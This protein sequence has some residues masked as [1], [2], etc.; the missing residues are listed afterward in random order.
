MLDTNPE[1][2]EKPSSMSEPV[3]R[4]WPTQVVDS[5]TLAIQIDSI[6][7]L[8]YPM[9]FNK[10]I[11]P[12]DKIVV[13]NSGTSDLRGHITV[14]IR[15][16]D[17]DLSTQSTKYVPIDKGKNEFLFED[18]NVELRPAAMLTES[19]ED[20]EIAVAIVVDDQLVV[21][22]KRTIDV[23][24]SR[25]WLYKP[26][27]AEATGL[28]LTTFVTPH[29][30]VLDTVLVKAQPH[31][32][33]L[34]KTAK[35]D[36]Y[37]RDEP[38]VIDAQV[39]AIVSALQEMDITYMN[40][41]TSWDQ[42]GQKLR[43]ATQMVGEVD[44]RA[45]T[46]LDSTILLASILE[47]IDIAPILFVVNGHAFLGY[48]RYDEGAFPNGPVEQNLDT[49]FAYIQ[50]DQ[51]RL[52]ETTLI[53]TSQLEESATSWALVQ[54]APVN[55]RFLNR[56]ESF[57][58]GIDVRYAR[59]ATK[60]R[61]IPVA[62]N[63]SDGKAV[64][65]EYL[66]PES[67]TSIFNIQR[68]PGKG[69]V[70]DRSNEPY[71]VTQWKNKLLDLS[72][73]NRLLNLTP[74]ARI[75]LAMPESGIAI[76]EDV[77]NS[78]KQIKLLPFDVSKAAEGVRNVN[79]FS[80]LAEEPIT[81]LFAKNG[82]L[83]TDLTNETY[84]AKLRNIASK[85]RVIEEETGSNNLFL[86]FGALKWTIND[87]QVSSP[88]VL[89]PIRL[90]STG[91]QTAFTFTLDDA[92]E[93]TPNFCLLEKF[94]QETD[95]KQIEALKNPPRDESG[96]DLSAIIQ[97]T[98]EAL[99]KINPEWRVEPSVGISIL[100][101]G[102]F[103][104]WKD[105]DESW[106]NFAESPL[107]K[108]LIETPTNPYEDAES[109]DE[110]PDLDAIA[111]TSP[112][113]ADGSQVVAIGKA[114]SGQTFVLEGPPGTG[115]SQTITNIL[116]KAIREGK[117]IL[118]V[119]AKGEALNV[120]KDRLAS[121]GLSQFV[122]DLHAKDSKLSQARAHVAMAM[123]IAPN[124]NENE[125]RKSVT[126][127]TDSA[128]VLARYAANLHSKNA[129]GFSLYSAESASRVTSGLD[130]MEVSYAFLKKA[131]KEVIEDILIELRK[132]PIAV[133][134]TLLSP[135]AGWRFIS[136]PI[137][138]ASAERIVELEAKIS[139]TFDKISTSVGLGATIASLNSVEAFDLL[140]K[141]LNSPEINVDEL[142]KANTPQWAEEV[143]NVLN[144]IKKFNSTPKLAMGFFGPQILVEPTAALFD[145]SKMVD[146]AGFFKRFGLRKALRLKL[147]PYVIPGTKI[148]NKQLTLVLE[149]LNI[150][151]A[152]AIALK[153]SLENLPT[154]EVPENWNPLIEDDVEESRSDIEWRKQIIDWIWPSS[155]ESLFPAQ[156]VLEALKNS[157]RIDASVKSAI[158]E[159]PSDLVEFLTLCGVETEE[160]R[161]WMSDSGLIK[162]WQSTAVARR[163]NTDPSITLDRW[164][165]VVDSLEVLRTHEL[166]DA[167]ANVLGGRI[168][169]DFLAS[170]F[171]Y[172]LATRSVGERSDEFGVERWD[173]VAHEKTIDAFIASQGRLTK[174]L[175]AAIAAGALSARK[176][177]PTLAS[178]RVGELIREVSRQRGG[179]LRDMIHNHLDLIQ[180]LTP[181]MMM[182]PDTVAR[183]LPAKAGLF[184]LVI[185][186]EASQ[187]RVAESIGALG[188]ATAAVV[189]G[190][191]KQM[192]PTSFAEAQVDI[193]ED[194][195]VA[196]FGEIVEDQESILD[197]LG[198][199]LM[200]K[201][202]RHMLSWHYRSH[203][204]S[205]ISFSNHAYYKGELSS[206]PAPFVSGK[207]SQKRDDYL[208]TPGVKWVRVKNGEYFADRSANSR[209][210]SKQDNAGF[211]QTNPVEAQA[212][213]DEI[214]R[215]FA[216][217]PDVSPSIGVVTLNQRQQKLISSML[218]G[219]TVPDRI[220]SALTDNE[221]F[222]KN[223][224][225]VQGDERD[226]ILFSIGRSAVKGRVPLN[227]G[228]I[229]NA[230]GERRL[231]VAITRARTQVVVFCSFSTS[232][233]PAESSASVGLQHLKDYLVRAESGA[234]KR[235]L[236]VNP[237]I[238][239]DNHR[240]DVAKALR[241]RGLN[242]EENLGLSDFRI[243]IAV[244]SKKD[245]RFAM[246]VLLDNEPWSQRQTV[247]DRDQLPVSVLRGLMGWKSVF[248]VWL[249]EW[250]TD[251]EAVL[252]RVLTEFTE[253]EALIAEEIKAGKS[254]R[255]VAPAPSTVPDPVD[256][257]EHTVE[258]FLIV[259]ET[260]VL[261]VKKARG[262]RQFSTRGGY[263]KLA[264]L[265][266]NIGGHGSDFDNLDE[267]AVNRIADAIVKIVK[268]RGPIHPL[269]L[270]EM[271]SQVYDRRKMTARFSKIVFA[272]IGQ[273]LDPKHVKV[274][275]DYL[276]AADA[277]PQSWSDFRGQDS[278]SDRKFDYIYPGEI[279]NAMRFVVEQTLG[280]KQDELRSEVLSIFGIQKVTNSA[281]LIFDDV[282][283]EGIKKRFFV[284]DSGTVVTMTPN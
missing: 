41:P 274:F 271:V 82:A 146:F 152:E 261:D 122:F 29:D 154:V 282:L 133:G 270:V 89:V 49:V 260:D 105:L 121:V 106:E 75:Q 252:D 34:D 255:K 210:G 126:E 64:V 96:L 207:E 55:D 197:E 24:G 257:A 44:Q 269:H 205:L 227:F 35:W 212:V 244:R 94:K 116:S 38:K 128:N 62:A 22:N 15:A 46:C 153:Q 127:A 259:S 139:T 164:L 278:S 51:M 112:I 199:I 21:A 135:D 95:G 124:F 54:K 208:D 37:Q 273:Y 219:P 101:F 159:T 156:G 245:D 193:D 90:A 253:T 130:P 60:I 170:A 81:D 189:V 162:R 9:A 97:E 125:Y 102:K 204:E 277:N 73:R 84:Q 247:G 239:D 47:R 141:L 281:V 13:I 19:A 203:D 78:G 202:Q 172:G 200:K 71:R 194:A 265:P 184:D 79:A 118:F 248:R 206:F 66:A 108:H 56:P 134:G 229:N 42:E 147:A 224:E 284:Q 107:V 178:G 223:I 114:L 228:P 148:A 186:D 36:G 87:R 151:A 262:T 8:S 191:T 250:L 28:L 68:E 267:G 48:W 263:N 113:Q 52:V 63:G 2:V 69:R 39:N 109:S 214:V 115:K 110:I 145:E 80:E 163:G 216:N 123:K 198:R 40:P 171:E 74:S 16:H 10:V 111:S 185:F 176:F 149:N 117:R 218:L 175:P 143:K 279:R 65:I 236:E 27:H 58:A 6:D 275:E 272:I 268:A 238:D 192:P 251:R 158:S 150:V 167:I 33:R 231:N 70:R 100:N 45:A 25:Q 183:L 243:D 72:L 12:F 140:A 280:I 195:Q 177:D 132:V 86:T 201:S 53:C 136:T 188:R 91:K 264:P 129:A 233:F 181:C 43:T 254:R 32:A 230:G 155:S 211:I 174:S 232:E 256:A 31:L 213:I 283:N 173:H 215:R 20:A 18:F 187:L 196:A 182:S 92:G 93:S 169:V 157:A 144:E 3:A 166:G 26:S 88:L 160:F 138:R 222:V 57:I 221:I 98:R 99:L 226:T 220:S 4:E 137:N 276:W 168:P 241:D 225:T 67:G 258:P 209:S 180:Q 61:P 131:S 23:L 179:S 14:V 30:P 104:L 242:V 7:E 217:S 246:A 5:P 103:R 77:V 120:V 266:R 249:P 11:R 59:R 234:H 50:A 17:R 235:A 83:L 119:A 240:E 76:L 1:I 190:D 237:L 142:E 85:A 161:D 165:N